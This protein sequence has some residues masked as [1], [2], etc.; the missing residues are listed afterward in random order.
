MSTTALPTLYSLEDTLQALEDTAEGGI[1]PEQQ[2]EF[3][4]ALQEAITTAAVKR[5]A[6]GRYRR[7]MQAQIDFAK[8]EISRLQT[9]VSRFQGRIE[10]LDAF[11]IAAMRNTGKRKLE[12]N[13]FTLSLRKNPDS[14]QID[15]AAKVPA[16]FLE[17]IPAVAESTRPDKRRIA[18]ALR[19]E[20]AV[21]GCTLRPGE[22]RL[23]VR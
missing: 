12:G 13:S 1:S 5:D 22:D 23:E 15:D 9:R 6:V 2:A 10:S 16:A 18:A 11:V 8:E 20:Q 4:A 19:A 7:H 14:V 17:I 3:E 21:P